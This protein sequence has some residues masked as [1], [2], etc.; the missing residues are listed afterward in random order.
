MG[1]IAKFLLLFL[2]LN[3]EKKNV[4]TFKNILTSIQLIMN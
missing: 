4:K 3:S 1:F 2:F